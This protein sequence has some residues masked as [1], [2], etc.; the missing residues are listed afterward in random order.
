MG[1]LLKTHV[2]EFYI[3]FHL[4]HTELL[5]PIEALVGFVGVLQKD[6]GIVSKNIQT[7]FYTQ[8]AAQP[9]KM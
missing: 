4:A 1:K 8:K 5:Q 2:T 3:K 6:S 9:I 7:K